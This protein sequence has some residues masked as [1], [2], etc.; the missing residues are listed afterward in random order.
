LFYA[1][2]VARLLTGQVDDLSEPPLRP[3]GEQ[4]AFIGGLAAACAGMH[5]VLGNRPGA[6]VDIS[7]QEALATLAMTE[8]S[9]AGQSGRSWERKRLADGNGATVTILP[10]NDGYTATSPVRTSS[11]RRGL[12]PW[13]RRPGEPIRA[14]RPNPTASQTLTRCMR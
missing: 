11:G 9:R 5:A 7:L 14:S 1:S 2:G 8:L 6:W 10:A 13:D 3:V 4:S 12:R